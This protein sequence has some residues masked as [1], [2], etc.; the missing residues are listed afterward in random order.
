MARMCSLDSESNESRDDLKLIKV[1]VKI[2]CN[3]LEGS[4][5][6]TSLKCV[7]NQYHIM[8]Q[9]FKNQLGLYCV[10]QTKTN[11]ETTLYSE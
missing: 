4:T 11:T 6:I 1:V 8:L 5:L 9:K 2:D 7:E 3:T 10:N